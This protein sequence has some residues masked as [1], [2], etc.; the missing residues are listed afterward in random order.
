MHARRAMRLC[1][2]WSQPMCSHSSAMIYSHLGTQLLVAHAAGAEQRVKNV[3]TD[4]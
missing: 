1:G 3:S 2:I 4:S